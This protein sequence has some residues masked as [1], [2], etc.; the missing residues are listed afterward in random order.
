MKVESLV[1]MLITFA[2]ITLITVSL[3]IK[4]LKNNKNSDEISEEEQ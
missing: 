1:F 2:V 3:F 4:V